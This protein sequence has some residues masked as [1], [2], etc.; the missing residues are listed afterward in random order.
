MVEENAFQPVQKTRASRAIEAQL[1]ELIARG[2]AKSG[3]RLPSERVLA[4]ALG[5]GR[6]TLREAIRILEFVGL[7]D[8]RPGAGTFVAAPIAVHGPGADATTARHTSEAANATA[9]HYRPTIQ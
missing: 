6:A 8:V 5:V 1:R 9:A 4:H 3:D 2:Q 7:L